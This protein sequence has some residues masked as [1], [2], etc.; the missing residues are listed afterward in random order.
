M[1]FV[2]ETPEILRFWMKD[3]DV[4]LSIAFFDR[5]RRLLQIEEMVP[6]IGIPDAF[7]P[8]YESREEAQYALEV[9]YGWF[10]T[11]SVRY[12]DPFTCNELE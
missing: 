11:H 2:F 12:G 1:L 10:E 4:P 6:G 8:V 5:E 9:P 7:Q 3:T